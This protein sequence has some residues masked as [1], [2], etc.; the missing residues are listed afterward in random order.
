[1]RE[2]TPHGHMQSPLPTEPPTMPGSREKQGS[3]LRRQAASPA[4]TPELPCDPPPPATAEAARISVSPGT[5]TH[6]QKE[7]FWAF[8]QELPECK[9]QGFLPRTQGFS[10]V[11]T[12]FV[13]DTLP[14]NSALDP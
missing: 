1:M 7:V 14:P 5:R 9:P 4:R 13:T 3:S 8:L 12:L 6:I 2:G 10:Q 11:P